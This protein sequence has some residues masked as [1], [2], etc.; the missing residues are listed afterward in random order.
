MDNSN[1]PIGNDTK[2]HWFR[3]VNDTMVDKSAS[4]SR[5]TE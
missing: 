2:N 4:D 5:L 1:Q 3:I